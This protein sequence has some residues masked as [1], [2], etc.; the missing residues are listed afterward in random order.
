M[1]TIDVEFSYDDLEVRDGRATMNAYVQ[2]LDS[3]TSECERTALREGLLR[4]CERDA[5][6][7]IRLVQFFE[8]L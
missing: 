2:I 5:G 6:A 7:L 4:Y 8:G 3:E 1:P